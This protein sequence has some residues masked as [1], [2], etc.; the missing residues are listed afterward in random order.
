MEQGDAATRAELAVR[1][2]IARVAHVADGGDL[3]ESR[4][5]YTEDAVWEFPGSAPRHGRDGILADVRQRRAEGVTGPGSATRHVI[6][7]LA[8]TVEDPAGTATADS[9]WL[10]YRDTTTAPVLLSMGHYHDTVR[11]DDGAWRIARRQITVG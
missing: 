3:E 7:T 2:L 1:N 5:L 8:V 9:Y 4:E 11:Y 10:Y 6:T